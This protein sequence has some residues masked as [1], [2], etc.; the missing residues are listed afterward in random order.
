MVLYG[1]GVPNQEWPD[2][3]RVTR[4]EYQVNS[5]KSIV[6]CQ[7]LYVKSDRSSVLCHEQNIKSITVKSDNSKVKSQQWHV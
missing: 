4:Q 7:D 2:Q 6:A 3:S 1:T 5:Y